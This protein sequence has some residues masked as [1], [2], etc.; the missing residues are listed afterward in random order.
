M[1]EMTA[2]PT[3]VYAQTVTVRGR[4][5]PPEWNPPEWE[6]WKITVMDALPT[7]RTMIVAKLAQ[8]FCLELDQDSPGPIFQGATATLS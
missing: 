6:E 5:D 8:I 3:S 2:G 4:H 1:M 7:S